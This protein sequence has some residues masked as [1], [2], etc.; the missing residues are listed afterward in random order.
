M[1]VDYLRQKWQKENWVGF[2]PVSRTGMYVEIW[3]GRPPKE[4][5]WAKGEDNRQ[6]G[7]VMFIPCGMALLVRGDTVHAGGMHCDKYKC[8]FGNPR[9]HIYIKIGDRALSTEE[10][11]NRWHDYDSQSESDDDTAE[12]KAVRTYPPFE[13]KRKNN[14]KLGYSV[15]GGIIR[16]ESSFSKVLLGEMRLK[17]SKTLTAGKR[18]LKKNALAGLPLKTEKKE[19]D[20]KPPAKR[21]KKIG[22]EAKIVQTKKETSSSK[23]K[24][25]SDMGYK[26]KDGKKKGKG[27]K[28]NV[29]RKHG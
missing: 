8:A 9:L 19:E 3:G 23:I 17:E 5:V 25:K 16:R 29:K 13:A 22:S 14:S 2:V 27:P 20:S 21:V 10:N 1:H 26:E 7:S 15:D 6:E 11:G 4:C 28:K 24:Q 18:A 12:R